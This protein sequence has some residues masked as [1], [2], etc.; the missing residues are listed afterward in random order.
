M[1]KNKIEWKK[2]KEANFNHEINIEGKMRNVKSKKSIKPKSYTYRVTIKGETV[3]LG[4]VNELRWNY[5]KGE[6]TSNLYF[7]GWKKINAM[8]SD[9]KPYYFVNEHGDVY[10]AKL[11]RFLQTREK[12]DGYLTV[13]IKPKE[14][15][16]HRLVG[17]FI[18]I[19]KKYNGLTYQDLTI[20]HINSIRNDNRKENLRWMTLEE[21]ISITHIEGRK[22][23]ENRIYKIAK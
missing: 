16:H 13:H 14:V 1:K 21:N 15:L 2:V 18:P 22:Y 11:D 3:R 20:D 6:I 8:Y 17:L 4:S 12:K 7:R 19:D 10:N 9:A 23:N 5:F